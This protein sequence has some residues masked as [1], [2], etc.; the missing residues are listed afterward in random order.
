VGKEEELKSSGKK[1]K[2]KLNN[3]Y[4]NAGS[5]LVKIENL[6]QVMEER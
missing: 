3:R 6:Y 4:S 1:I 2:V 5:N